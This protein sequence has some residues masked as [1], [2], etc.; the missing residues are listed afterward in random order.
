MVAGR[1]FTLSCDEGICSSALAKN[2]TAESATDEPKPLVATGI[3][4][5]GTDFAMTSSIGQE[6][7]AMRL[8][9]DQIPL[10]T[11]CRF[12]K[13]HRKTTS[14]T[15]SG[16]SISEIQHWISGAAATASELSAAAG[17]TATYSGGLVGTVAGAGILQE[18]TG[19]F[20]ARVKFGVSQYQVQNFSADFDGSRYSGASGFT[21]NNTV[22]DVTGSSGARTLQAGGYFF[23][24]TTRGNAPPNIGGHFKVTGHDYHAAG[25][26]A[27][28][29]R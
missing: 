21:P 1:T 27:G 4:D 14:I 25:V 23:G 8:V 22:F 7:S 20:N 17:K 13:W 19:S 6:N 29:Q 9:G 12:L 3:F 24:S 15:E 2:L 18:T 10:C 16:H 28:A 26:F 11:D 5:A